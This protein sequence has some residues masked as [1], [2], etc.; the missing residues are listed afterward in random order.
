MSDVV[1]VDATALISLGTIGELDLLLNFDGDIV[2]PAR[3]AT[4]VSTEPAST[5]LE[6]F[7][8]H[9]DVKHLETP[10][11]WA[12]VTR[13]ANILDADSVT[14]DVALVA[15]V[16][17]FD[18]SAS[19][20]VVSD[21][22]R[23]RTVSAGLGATVTGTIGVVVRAVHDGLAVEDGKELVRRIDGNGLHMTGEL[24]DTAFDLLEDA[25]DRE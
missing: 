24:R 25:G 19:S 20:A 7:L 2:I 11:E 21:D 5:N 18:G 8:H 13:A 16:L 15:N 10:E 12:S 1:L 4:E 23:V 3:V 6:R 9:D 22:R 14:G 17:S